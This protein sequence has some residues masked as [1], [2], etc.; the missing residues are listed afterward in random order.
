MQ[1]TRVPLAAIVLLL[2]VQL[3]Y[4]QVEKV[5]VE[6]WIAELSSNDPAR[7]KLAAEMLGGMKAEAAPAI[8]A[9]VKALSDE[10]VAERN[11]LFTT[12]VCDSAFEALV[13]IGEP[14]VPAFLSLLETEKDKDRRHRIL[15]SL[16]Q[17]GGPA[18][19]AIPPLKA[20]INSDVSE[21]ERFYA[22][23]ALALIHSPGPELVAF[24]LDQLND[25]SP[26]FRY[27]AI[28]AL[29]ICGKDAAPA[30]NALINLLSDRASRTHA[31]SNHAFTTRPLRADAAEALGKIGP[32]AAAAIPRLN[33]MMLSDKDDFARTAAAVA[34][35]RINPADPIGLAFLQSLLTDE[36][37]DEHTLETAAYALADLGPAAKGSLPALVKLLQH[38]SDD[39]RWPTIYAIGEI[40]G[41]D[42]I[43]LLKP[44]LNDK[45]E[46][47]R[48]QVQ[49]TIEDLQSK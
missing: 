10:R 48:E 14:A 39:V 38:E 36:K 34:L 46:F 27:I 22:F 7:A 16:G 35:A 31:I 45:D 24:A 17:I 19:K 32:P 12:R 6:T 41:K 25:K 20:I 3:L 9:L 11:M 4:A 28:D 8:P 13:S 23:N 44:A 40:G 29:G 26:N 47:I 1:R 2:A 5:A 15:R 21:R 42:A 37:S 49:D 30:V 33:K 43:P 18:A